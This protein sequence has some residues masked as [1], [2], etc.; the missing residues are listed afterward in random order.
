M[1]IK[2]R[3]YLQKRL[4][5]GLN[6][7]WLASLVVRIEIQDHLS[8]RLYPYSFTL[9]TAV[10]LFNYFIDDM[11]LLSKG[12]TF[13]PSPFRQER[14]TRINRNSSTTSPPNGGGLNFYFTNSLPPQQI[15]TYFW[16]S[17]NYTSHL[18]AL[19]GSP[20]MYFTFS[21]LFLNAALRLSLT[22]IGCVPFISPPSVEQI[23]SC[24]TRSLLPHKY[25]QFHRRVFIVRWISE[26]MLLTH[27]LT[28][29][30]FPWKT[31]F[32]FKFCTS[33]DIA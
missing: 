33:T 25:E 6:L 5:K 15:Q 11:C 32:N 3:F 22:W 21:H 24:H 23:F 27:I 10:E 29:S 31:E 30:P 8:F 17:K 28:Q 14:P 26:K 4:K 16:N 7:F 19:I 1:Q 18:P 9:S 12:N 13:T 20:T 2:N